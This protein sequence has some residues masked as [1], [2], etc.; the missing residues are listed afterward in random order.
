MVNLP[1]IQTLDALQVFCL[2]PRVTPGCQCSCGYDRYVKS[3]VHTYYGESYTE[4]DANGHHTLQ[5][6]GKHQVEH[7]HTRLHQL[8][9]LLFWLHGASCKVYAPAANTGAVRSSCRCTCQAGTEACCNLPVV[10]AVLT[11]KKRCVF[12]RLVIA[13]DRCIHEPSIHYS[14]YCTIVGSI[15]IFI[16]FYMS[17]TMLVMYRISNVYMSFFFSCC[18]KQKFRVSLVCRV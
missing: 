9:S 11:V 2:G 8:A 10:P 6:S 17:I 18:K 4:C 7:R 16:F 3:T 14:V 13:N 1:N 15:F 12:S 5:M